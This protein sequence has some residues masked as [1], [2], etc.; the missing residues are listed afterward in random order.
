M[1]ATEPENQSTENSNGVWE[2]GLRID[3]E[4]SNHG[5]SELTFSAESRA[6]QGDRK[7]GNHSPSRGREA[8]QLRPQWMDRESG[9]NDPSEVIGSAGPETRQRD[10]KF[11]NQWEEQEQRYQWSNREHGSRL[12]ASGQEVQGTGSQWRHSKHYL[13]SKM[14][15]HP[16]Y[17]DCSKVDYCSIPAFF[18]TVLHT[19]VDNANLF[20]Q[21]YLIASLF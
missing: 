15:N 4:N 16:D 19:K 5:P 13:V 3:G 11:G 2:L 17:L 8:G 10:R 12:P 9:D 21:W 20:S 6:C 14:H 18:F 1:K 7:R